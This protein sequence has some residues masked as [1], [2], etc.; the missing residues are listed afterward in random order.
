MPV[1][2]SKYNPKVVAINLTLRNMLWCL[3]V[4]YRPVCDPQVDPTL[5]SGRG[6]GERRRGRDWQNYVAS[7]TLLKEVC[8]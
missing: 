6:G 1:P 3:M 7:M 5:S 2:V 8:C 4:H